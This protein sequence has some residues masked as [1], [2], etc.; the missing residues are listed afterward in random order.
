MSQSIRDGK[1]MTGLEGKGS[2]GTNRKDFALDM[3]VSYYNQNL[4][5]LFRMSLTPRLRNRTFRR[6]K[7]IRKME[8][9]IKI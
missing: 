7:K 8:T 3:F 6:K 5:F 4:N 1:K 2:P 9:R